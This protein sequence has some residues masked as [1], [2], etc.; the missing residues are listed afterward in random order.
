MKRFMSF[1]VVLI[2]ICLSLVACSN[3]PVVIDYPNVSDFEAALNAGE[4]LVGK[5]VTF[6][7]KEFVSDS[8]FGYNLQAGEHLN[9]CSTDNPGMKTGDTVS[10]R[11]IS[12][13]SI[14]KSFIIEYEIVD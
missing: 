13:K 9:F 2:V 6:T 7:V 8:A 4:D 3:E 1:F 12:V 11:V 10:V 5:T 14:M